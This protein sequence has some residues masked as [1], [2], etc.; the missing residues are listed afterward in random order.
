[1][2][3][4]FW[5]ST[6]SKT[7]FLGVFP[8]FPI[9][10]WKDFCH[11]YIVYYRRISYGCDKVFWSLPLLFLNILY[12]GLLML[13][14]CICKLCLEIDIDWLKCT[15]KNPTFITLKDHKT[16]FRTCTPCRL[17]NPCKSELGKI[18]K[19]ILE[20]AKKYLVDLLN[21]NQWKNSDMVINWFCSIKSKLQCTF[22]Q[23]DIMELYPSMMET[24]L[25][26]ALSMPN[27][28]QKFWM[29]SYE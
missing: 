5:L 19:M 15:A 16:N 27:N 12:L 20:T 17:L 6:I 3:G 28:T 21:L 29:K 14:Q 7:N 8:L 1:M 11:S 10:T 25:D 23:L 4:P 22:I 18:S 24:I 2:Q 13:K 26:N 9:Y